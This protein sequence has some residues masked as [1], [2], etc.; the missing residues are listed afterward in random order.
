MS[1]TTIELRIRDFIATEFL[2]WGRIMSQTARVTVWT[3]VLLCLAA[4]GAHA[5]EPTGKFARTPTTWYYFANYL[6]PDLGTLLSSQNQRIVDVHV[7]QTSPLTLT[8]ATVSEATPPYAISWW[9][10]GV[11]ASQVAA[12][13]TQ[14]SPRLTN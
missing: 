8:G 4:A 10:Y 2:S 14:H 11:S 5:V 6:V 1:I 7:V 9:Y 13:L 3:L 12:D